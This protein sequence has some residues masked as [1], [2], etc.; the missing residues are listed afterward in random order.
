[1]NKKF[2]KELADLPGTSGDEYRVKNYLKQNL[3]G[4]DSFI[5]DGLGGIVGVL[6]SGKKGKNILVLAH[7]DEVGFMVKS[8][9]DR[10]LVTL[11]NIGGFVPAVLT[12]QR[13]ILHSDK[14]DYEGVILGLPPHG[15]KDKNKE[16]TVEE[17]HVDFGFVSNKDAEKK[18][19][20]IG[21]F[22]TFKNDYQELENNRVVSKAFDNRLGCAALLELFKTYKTKLKKGKI[23]LG[24]SVQEEA[25][26]RGA[27]PIV[28]A[29]NDKIDYALIIDVSPVTDFDKVTNGSLGEGT[30]IRV[31]DP[32]CILDPKE[33]RELRKLAKASKIK[34]QEFF[35]AGGTDAAQVQI[36][37]DGYTT[38][39][40]CVPGRSIHTNNTI[41]DFKD[42]E[43]TLKLA[44]KYIDSKIK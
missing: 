33:V 41:I 43:A 5:E 23:Y 31:K 21:D 11:T 24:A 17:L 4:V 35:S 32:R 27:G 39:A 22:V 36:T 19:V 29:I 38:C 10:G 6:D 12:S 25:G 34:Y 28:N 1:M 14:K 40:L 20:M 44:T 15:N 2:V 42:Y 30:L 7:M 3:K 16:F 13:V 18:G 26:L 9:N 8:I 37:N